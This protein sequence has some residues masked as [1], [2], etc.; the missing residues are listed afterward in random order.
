M[1]CRWNV[2]HGCAYWIVD[3]WTKVSLDTFGQ[4]AAASVSVK[5][6]T[7]ART[8][9][10]A[11]RHEPVRTGGAEHLAER[12][13]DQV[14]GPGVAHPEV[15][16]GEPCGHLP[17]VEDRRQLRD[18]ARRAGSQRHVG[19][20]ELD[21]GQPEPLTPLEADEGPAAAVDA[22]ARRAAFL[23]PVEDLGFAGQSAAASEGAQHVDEL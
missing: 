4:L 21:Q 16:P 11:R 12:F 14:D 22:P 2:V 1:N 3:R 23:R 10:S 9:R 18:D 17:A 6:A 5:G 20:V 19:G 15:R 7:A 13:V 8:K